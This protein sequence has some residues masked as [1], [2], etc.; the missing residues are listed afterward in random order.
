M[1][2]EVFKL[3]FSFEQDLHAFNYVYFSIFNLHIKQEINIIILQFSYAKEMVVVDGTF[4]PSK[5]KPRKVAKHGLL[6]LPCGSF[7]VC[8]FN[9]EYKF[10]TFRPVRVT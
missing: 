10:P 6:G 9:P 3:V 7:Q 4:V 8:V 2:L 1:L 5:T